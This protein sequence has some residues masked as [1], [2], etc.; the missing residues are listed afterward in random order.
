MVV[1]TL[2]QPPEPTVTSVFLMLPALLLQPIC[3]TTPI[4]SVTVADANVCSIETTAEFT[5][6]VNTTALPTTLESQHTGCTLGGTTGRQH[7][8]V[9]PRVPQCIP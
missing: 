6:E 1:H 7:L 3:T 5:V 2:Q 8:S 4:V 9:A